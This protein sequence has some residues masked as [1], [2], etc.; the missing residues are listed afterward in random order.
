[1]KSVRLLLLHFFFYGFIQLYLLSVLDF[2]YNLKADI[3]N[4]F[5]PRNYIQG[6][7]STMPIIALMN[8]HHIS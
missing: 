3:F 6:K 1:M 8:G 7:E 4:S 2:C 5:Y